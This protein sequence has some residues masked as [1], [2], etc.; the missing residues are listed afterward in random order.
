MEVTQ[1]QNLCD[2]MQAVID[3]PKSRKWDLI[4]ISP[5]FYVQ[6]FYTKVFWAV[7]LYLQFVFVIFFQ[8]E[9]DEKTELKCLWNLS[10]LT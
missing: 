10:L 8:K 4:S 1:S 9:I 5:K 2:V 6:L 7:F 3:D